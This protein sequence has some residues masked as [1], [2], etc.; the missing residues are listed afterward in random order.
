MASKRTA[1]RASSTRQTT[2]SK[3]SGA[4]PSKGIASPRERGSAQGATSARANRTSETGQGTSRLVQP[5]VASR[6][7]ASGLVNQ[8]QARHLASAS[9]RDA[10]IALADL[11]EGAALTGISEDIGALS[12][13]AGALSLQE[14]E[15]G[16]ELAGM[17]GQIG[18]VGDAVRALGMGSLGSFL[19][20]MSRRMRDMAVRD[21]L[22]AQDTRGLAQAIGEVGAGVES[23]GEGELATGIA[24]LTS[25]QAVADASELAADIG[26][27]QIAE[28]LSE[29]AAPEIQ[30]STGKKA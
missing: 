17:A 6:R 2:R 16:M 28:G 26:S 23:I 5:D 14:V 27:R 13:A 20:E 21:M 12:V 9:A 4:R 19:E 22:Q 25:A 7:I 8:E 30:T 11:D 10:R 29:A 15:R 24:E 1:K 18:T 3:S